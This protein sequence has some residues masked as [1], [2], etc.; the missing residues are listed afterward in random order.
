[1]VTKILAVICAIYFL[2][3]A[4][5]TVIFAGRMG[6]YDVFDVDRINLDH[7]D[8]AWD[9]IVTL[10]IWLTFISVTFTYQ[11]FESLV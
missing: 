5:Q 10:I 1:M 3:A 8:V 2:V 7:V 6:W 9:A 11:Y 4:I